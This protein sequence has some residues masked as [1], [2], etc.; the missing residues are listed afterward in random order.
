MKTLW[1]KAFKNQPSA[2][3]INFTAGHDVVG[4]KAADYHL[5]PYDI[6]GS[7]AH[8]FMLYEQK[9]I[10]KEDAEMIFTAR[11]EISN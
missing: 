2:A 9:I 10:G 8:V 3:V 4:K 7:Q 1:G 5:L 11:V 6:L